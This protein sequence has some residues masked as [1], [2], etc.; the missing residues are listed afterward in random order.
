MNT[1]YPPFLQLL[2][3]SDPELFRTLAESHDQIMNQGVLERKIKLLISLAVDVFAG[4]P[5]VKPLA[6]A[7]RQA[8]ATEAE[9]LETLQLA[10][11][12][13]AGNPVTEEDWCELKAAAG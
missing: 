5:G 3:K 1:P 2:E 6:E 7:A 13:A 12:L 8:G 9:I 4:S 10:D 11:H